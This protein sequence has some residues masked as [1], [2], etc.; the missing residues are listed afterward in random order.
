MAFDPPQNWTIANK[1]NYLESRREIIRAA[2]LQDNRL[3]AVA[4]DALDMAE[5]AVF[6]AVRE[7]AIEKG[8][9]NSVWGDY[10]KS[11]GQPLQ[12]MLDRA[13]EDI[14]LI[15]KAFDD[16]GNPV[17]PSK[18]VDGIYSSAPQAQKEIATVLRSISHMYGYEAVI[19]EQKDRERADFVVENRYQGDASKLT[20]VARGAIVCKTMDDVYFAMHC[21]SQSYKN[22]IIKDRF[23]DPPT[24]AYRDLCVIV[25]T[26]DSHFAEIQIHL[27]SYWLAKKHKGDDLYQQGR[28]LCLCVQ[29]DLTPDQKK[30]RRKLYEQARKLYKEAGQ[31][32]GFTSKKPSATPVIKYP[33]FLARF[34]GSSVESEPR[35][36]RVTSQSSHCEAAPACV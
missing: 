19:T 35:A 34:D 23:E 18:T 26:D 10:L 6:V 9:S 2:N 21:L 11:A 22:M 32:H 15:E 24:T 28:D 1:V 25:R 17:Q 33:E 31:P 7:R 12:K 36:V 8:F 5:R 16:E 20:D 29:G 30:T 13:V 4:E 27:E 3:V 14:E